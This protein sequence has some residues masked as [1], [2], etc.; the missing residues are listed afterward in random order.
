VY[1]VNLY[2]SLD[3]EVPQE[4][5]SIEDREVDIKFHDRT[6]YDLKIAQVP[7]DYIDLVNEL[8][9]LAKDNKLSE[10]AEAILD[11][12]AKSKK[13][14]GTP[15]KYSDLPEGPFAIERTVYVEREDDKDTIFGKAFDFSGS[16]IID[17]FEKGEAAWSKVYERA[18][19]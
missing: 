2:P 6:K 1:I 3:A 19:A 5:D 18:V 4:P 10:K 7:I 8:V 13:C 16:T 14:D 9:Q 11:R 12:T 15:R 17:L